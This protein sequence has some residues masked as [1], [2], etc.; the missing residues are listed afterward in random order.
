MNNLEKYSKDLDKLIEE[1]RTLVVSLSYESSGHDE[2]RK[3][4]EK[5]HPG[6][7]IEKLIKT[8]P[9][10]AKAY[11]HWYSEALPLVRQ[12][13]PDRL[14]DF[15][16][17]YEKPKSRKDI[18][19]ES[20][21][22]EDACKG[23]RSSFGGTVRA[24]QSSAIPL[25]NQQIAIV[26]AIKRR[27]VSS[28]FDIKQ[29]VQADL[30]DSELDG[31]KELLKNNFFRA[32]GAMAGVVLEGHLKQVCDNH[33]LPKKS[34]TIGVLNDTL[35]AAA[36]IDL[37]QTRHIQFLGDLRNKCSHKNSAEPTTEEIDDLIQGVA[38]VVKT[39]F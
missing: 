38:K 19:F 21:R 29:L 23:L 30:F 12:L 28:L 35:K 17:L 16:R 2:F 8:I 3:V 31:A 18:D 10:F 37:P 39:I 26:E 6:V 27:F 7:D 9:T 20:Y 36:V 24:D 15:V 14:G 34:G 1:S 33:G 13:L 22:I 4:N 25:L 5:A 32:A 11:E